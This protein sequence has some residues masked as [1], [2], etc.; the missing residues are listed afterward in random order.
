VKEPVSGNFH[1]FEDAKFQ[2]ESRPVAAD[3]SATVIFNLK[4]EKCKHF[5]HYPE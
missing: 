1:E 4:A 3:M 5:E 2:K